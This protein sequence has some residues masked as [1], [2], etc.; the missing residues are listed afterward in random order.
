MDLDKGIMKQL[1]EKNKKLIIYGSLAAVEAIIIIWLVV[2]INNLKIANLTVESLTSQLSDLRETTNNLVK[3]NDELQNKVEI[4][5]D[6]VNDK[7]QKEE[8]REAQIA[9]SYVPTGY[10]IKGTASYNDTV[11]ELDGNPIAYF[12]AQQGTSVVAAANGTVASIAVGETGERII[13]IDHGNGYCS[14]YRSS[15][16]PKIS[17]GAEVTNQTELFETGVGSELLGYQ[18]S[19]DGKYI[20]PMGL[21]AIDG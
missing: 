19:K 17:E 20:D 11:T 12:Q 10:P 2:M 1:F 14:I 18:I 21:M 8:E 13:T 7:V 9:Q 6:T 3:E 4:L 16:E 15:A 5:S